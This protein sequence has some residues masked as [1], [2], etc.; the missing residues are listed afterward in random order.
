MTKYEFLVIILEN[1][2]ISK[3]AKGQSFMSAYFDSNV[4]ANTRYFSP[5][6]FGL[7]RQNLTFYGTQFKLSGVQNHTVFSSLS[8]LN[9]DSLEHFNQIIKKNLTLDNFKV[10]SS[11]SKNYEL[12]SEVSFKDTVSGNTI[13]LK[14]S[15]ENLNKL[16]LHFGSHNLSQ[17]N[18]KIVLSGEAEKFVSGWFGDIAFKRNY[19]GADSDKNGFLND[20]E[21]ALTYAGYSSE[22]SITLSANRSSNIDSVNFHGIS[23]YLPYNK[24]YDA[25]LTNT[26]EKELNATL[27]ADVNMNGYLTL[28]EL[29]SKQSIFDL[30]KK[31]IEGKSSGIVDVLAIDIEE[32]LKRLLIEETR[33]QL[34]SELEKQLNAEQYASYEEYILAFKDE[35]KTLSLSLKVG[36]KLIINNLNNP[37][38]SSDMHNLISEITKNA[39]SS[40]NLDLS[41]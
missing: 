13:N 21:K 5:S 20:E 11:L 12:S 18:G 8:H 22:N 3:E 19:V 33:K 38:F 31:N 24:H 37:D 40:L 9:K 41:V 28:G 14:L 4:G 32:F 16:K 35:I 34:E 23:S 6:N 1:F 25:Q 7:V 10:S 17:E 29:Q 26:I 36:E 30:A 39:Q 27:K 15:D 2:K